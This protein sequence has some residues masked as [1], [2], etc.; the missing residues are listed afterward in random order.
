MDNFDTFT[1]TAEDFG[2]DEAAANTYN[3]LPAYKRRR[4]YGQLKGGPGRKSLYGARMS[5][6]SVPLSEH[7]LEIARHLGDGN[8]RA[9]IR[10]AQESHDLL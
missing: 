8:V 6:K 9:G 1:A 2:G 10:T 3:S 5:P 7:H 4:I